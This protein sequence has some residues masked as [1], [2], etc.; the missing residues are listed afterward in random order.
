MQ[1]ITAQDLEKTVA[2]RASRLP[3]SEVLDAVR[4]I[5]DDVRARGDL[6]LIDSAA[7]YD[8]VELRLDQIEVS[9]EEIDASVAC[10][11]PDLARA[12]DYASARVLGFHLAT[13]PQD[14]SCVT[15]DGA[16]YVRTVEPLASAGIYAPKGRSGYP[17]SVIM[18]AS[19]ARA[20]G[21]QDIILCTPPGTQA[22]VS[23]AV[24]YAARVSGVE[25]V[26]R[27]GGAAAIA[28]MGLGTG[29]VPRVCKIAGPG[30]EY[31]SQAKRLLYGV[32]GIDLI[33][34][35]SEVAV[36]AD[37]SADP[38]LVAAD[39]L[40]QAEHGSNSWA[41]LITSSCTLAEQVR[42]EVERAPVE[43]RVDNVRCV[44]VPGI[45]EGARLVSDL[46][47]EHL[48]VFVSE[49]GR[50]LPL[51]KNCGAVFIGPWACAPLGD[52]ALGPNHVLPTAGAG[53]FCSGL[54]AAD[55][56][57]YVTV[58]T[59][60]GPPDCDLIEA[61]RAIALAEGYTRHAEAIVARGASVSEE[62]GKQA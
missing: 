45:E 37:S 5:V 15:P 1:I 30:N 19:A 55:F 18:C 43:G 52:F 13:R 12:I 56:I 61:S 20:A 14:Q 26:F 8:R 17:S 21:V 11:P 28:A 29:T 59:I 48:E 51:V 38:R 62:G 27:V 54:S 24:L 34:G 22:Q 32:V 9:P 23:P 3:Y 7:K 58:S 16:Q 41:V 25:R 47:P 36:L 44:V 46:A 39:L 10:I 35:P 53:R 57:R 4:R 42:V 31:V 49:P 2:E 50:V 40:A 33:A 6:A 60:P